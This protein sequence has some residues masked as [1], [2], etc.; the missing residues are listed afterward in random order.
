MKP[1][2]CWR[3]SSVLMRRVD[4]HRLPRTVPAPV[5]VFLL[6][7]MVLS[8]APLRGERLP[9]NGWRVLAVAYPE[10]RDV[11]VVLGGAEK[12]LIS[13]GLCKVRWKD[14]A[15]NLEL[16]LENLPSPSDAGWS[17]TQYV[18]WAVDNE[19][20]TMNLSLVPTNGGEA[21]WTV[22]VPFRIF[23][24]LITAEKNPQATNP[25][26]NVALESL[27]PTDSRLVV[28]AFRVDLSLTP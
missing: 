27:L 20:R 11:E 21:E 8:T 24:L 12:T 7:T 14:N 2:S 17:G 9:N 13:R 1:G 6:W 18:L 4:K 3:P 25:S 22:Q 26:I 10:D 19:K 23:G 16:K 28:P 5:A 15:A